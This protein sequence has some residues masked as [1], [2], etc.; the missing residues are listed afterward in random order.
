MTAVVN[1]LATGSS[2]N[3]T[4]YTSASFT[5]AASDYLLVFVHASDTTVAG[6][7]SDSQGLSWSNLAS[8]PSN[9][10]N[11]LNVFIS[12]TTA[13][14]TAMTVTWDC[15]ADASTGAIISVVRVS[16]SDGNVR[17]ITY[18]SDVAA[19]TP[20]VTFPMPV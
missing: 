9:S 8:I 11:V 3:T 10:T 6:T 17:Q 5:P 1:G 15:S 18:G 4:S 16:G 7:L 20:N 12:T 19:V 13:A 2:S 14:N